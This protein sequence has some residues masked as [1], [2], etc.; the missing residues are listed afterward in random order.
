M[1]MALVGMAS[2][3]QPLV[4]LAIR[5]YDWHPDSGYPMHV[6]RFGKVFFRDKMKFPADIIDTAPQYNHK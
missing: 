2:K 5:S 6:H 1:V 3:L 4:L